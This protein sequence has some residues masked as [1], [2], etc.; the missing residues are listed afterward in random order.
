MRHA[1]LSVMFYS[2]DARQRNKCVAP[3]FVLSPCFVY[4]PFPTVLLYSVLFFWPHIVGPSGIVSLLMRDLVR[5]PW[6]SGRWRAK[7]RTKRS[8]VSIARTNPDWNGKKKEKK[9]KRSGKE[10]NFAPRAVWQ[11]KMLSRQSEKKQVSN[12]DLFLFTCQV[13]P[14]MLQYD[15]TCICTNMFQKCTF[16][17]SLKKTTIKWGFVFIH[18]PGINKP[19]QPSTIAIITPSTKYHH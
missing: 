7:P 6:R 17:W 16:L 10:D 4:T 15:L 19:S 8:L 5:R 14:N 11:K 9:I 1:L 12:E 2:L 13:C 18:M 3:F